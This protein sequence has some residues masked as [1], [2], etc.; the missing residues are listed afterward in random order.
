MTVVQIEKQKRGR[1]PK[2][3]PTPIADVLKRREA[4][5]ALL[6]RRLDQIGAEISKLEVER[7]S[8]HAALGVSAPER[9]KDDS[10][11]DGM[12]GVARCADCGALAPRDSVRCPSCHTEPFEAAQ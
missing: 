1:K 8:I 5:N 7:G 10:E 9:R 12:V 11:E 2:A 3:T 6:R 4:D